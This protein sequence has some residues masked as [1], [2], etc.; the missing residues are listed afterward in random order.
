MIVQHAMPLAV[1]QSFWYHSR[2][3]VPYT[4]AEVDLIKAGRLDEVP[5]SNDEDTSMVFL[6]QCPSCGQLHPVSVPI[7]LH[8]KLVA[9]QRESC[10]MC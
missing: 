1:A 8:L 10:C 2:S 6:P 5:D 9:E 3:G 4:S 7:D